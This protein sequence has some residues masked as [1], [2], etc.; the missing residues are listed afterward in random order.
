MREL[1]IYVTSLIHGKSIDPNTEPYSE[2]H[3]NMYHIL[4]QVEEMGVTDK[5]PSFVHTKEGE[6]LVQQN[7]NLFKF[8]LLYNPLHFES[9]MKLANTYDEVIRL[10]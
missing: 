5:F 7:D 10:F 6:D 1:E 3:G 8:D 9:W 4:A 2:V